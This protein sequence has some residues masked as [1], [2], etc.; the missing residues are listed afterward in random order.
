VGL[1]VGHCRYDGSY[2]SVHW[3]K[4]DS[5][6][7]AMV[8]TCLKAE[9]NQETASVLFCFFV[10]CTVV[11]DNSLDAVQMVIGELRCGSA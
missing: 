7:R 6:K 3:T 9:C 8:P 5:W 1:F 11:T 4:K 2:G 10:D